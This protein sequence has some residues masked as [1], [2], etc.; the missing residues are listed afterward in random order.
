M[1]SKSLR[2]V[3]LLTVGW[4]A[5]ACQESSP[6]TPAEADLGLQ[7]ALTADGEAA[8]RSGDPER[9][10]ALRHAATSLRWGIRPS[11]IEVKIQNE[12]VTYLAIV[13]GV[14]RRGSDGSSVLVRSLVAWTGRPPTALFHVISASDQA[15]FGPPGGNGN[16]TGGPDGARGQWKDLVN[17]QLW[18]A[19]AGSAGLELAA[20]GNACP[21]QPL[22]VRLRCVLATFDIRIN[23]SFQLRGSGGPDGSP[24]EIHTNADGVH[25]VVL[26]P[27][28]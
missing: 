21:I 5:V 13:V 25:G 15:V 4:L 14:T 28:D 19:T 3:A 1:L 6:T 20:T 11:R 27:A 26:K 9:A 8:I 12:Q 22:D 17:H 7:A 16:G 18:V 2:S 23:G 24:I 10:E